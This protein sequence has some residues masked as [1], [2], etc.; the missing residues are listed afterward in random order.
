[1]PVLTYSFQMHSFSTPFLFLYSFS[2]PFQ[3]VEKGCIGNELFKSVAFGVFI[4]KL[5]L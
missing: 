2:T 1:M 3:E 5:E 4:V